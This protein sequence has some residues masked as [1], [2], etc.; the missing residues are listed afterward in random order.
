MSLFYYVI[1]ERMSVYVMDMEKIIEILEGMNG[2]QFVVLFLAIGALVSWG[3]PKLEQLKEWINKMYEKKKQKD[4]ILETILANKQEIEHLRDKNDEYYQA[5][6]GMESNFT[7]AINEL[8]DMILGLSNDS[9]VRY[10][11]SLRSEILDFCN[12]CTIRSYKQESYGHIFDLHKEYV[13]IIEKR[14]DTNGQMDESWEVM[15]GTYREH[16]AKGDFIEDKYEV[17]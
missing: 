15:L 8:K 4:E 13:D 12:A 10:I 1:P 5:L 9:E 3:I 6:K 14:G 17:R 2:M 7:S 11:Q 16:I